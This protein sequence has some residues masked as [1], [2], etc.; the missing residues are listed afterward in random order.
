MGQDHGIHDGRMEPEVQVDFVGF[1]ASAL[2]ETAIKEDMGAID[3][4]KVFGAGHG[5]RAAEKMPLHA[6]SFAG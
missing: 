1:L 3:F 6:V 2:E 4:E 5:V